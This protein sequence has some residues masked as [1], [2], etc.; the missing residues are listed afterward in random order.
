M[1]LWARQEPAE[2]LALM[3]ILLSLC[4]LSMLAVD[5]PMRT[6]LWVDQ[7]HGGMREIGEGVRLMAWLGGHTPAIV[8]G[9]LAGAT[10]SAVLLLLGV[11]P[12]LSALV[13]LQLL[14]ALASSGQPG[15]SQEYLVSNGLWLLVFARSDATLSLTARIRTGQWRP[16]VEIPAWPR[17]LGILQLILVYHSAGIQKVSAFWLPGGELSA[18]YYV[19]NQVSWYRWD[20]SEMWVSLY[21]LTQLATLSVWCFEVSAPLL[22]VVLYF[23]TTRTRP[24]RLR[25]LCNRL[26][27]R[28]AFAL[29]GLGMHAGIM[30]LMAV[31]AF[32]A[33]SLSF[34]PCL[35]H[36]DE[37]RRGIRAARGMRRTTPPS[38]R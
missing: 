2:S 4:I 31:G 26:P 8:D 27:L 19:L 32:S 25:A 3:R 17:Y 16:R 13:C 23:R 5:I 22:L 15:G 6:L 1:A 36:P 21:P 12:R 24:G 38:A 30:L 7:A 33:L 18:L 11:L 20:L 35:F 37:V 29:F 34:Y 28:S 9:V 10:I 14:L